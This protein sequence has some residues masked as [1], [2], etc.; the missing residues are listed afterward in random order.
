MKNRNAICVNNELDTTPDQVSKK[1]YYGR[2]HQLDNLGKRL[3]FMVTN[4]LEEGKE[5]HE[6]MFMKPMWMDWYD[7][8][9]GAIIGVKV[10]ENLGIFAEGRY[11][12]YWDRPAYDFK[13]GLNYQFVG[14]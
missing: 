4:H 8:D 11:L 7:Y 5:P 6:F 2:V 13:V 3:S 9:I 14:I 12:Y 10:Q 1:F